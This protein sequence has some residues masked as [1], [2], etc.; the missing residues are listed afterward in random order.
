MNTYIQISLANDK[1]DDNYDIFIFL[2]F[3]I[4]TLKRVGHAFSVKISLRM[5]LSNGYFL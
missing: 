1:N 2:L 5:N 3:P 4:K